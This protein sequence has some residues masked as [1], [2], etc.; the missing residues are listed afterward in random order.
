LQETCRKLAGNFAGKFLQSH[1]K[2][3]E[4]SCK[5]VPASFLQK[6]Y[7]MFPAIFVQIYCKFVVSF[8]HVSV[9]QYLLQMRYSIV[10]VIFFASHPFWLER[11]L[12]VVIRIDARPRRQ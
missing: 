3:Q 8:L 5:N 10:L 12:H 6:N 1:E 4:I 2:L 9:L 11:R 7:E